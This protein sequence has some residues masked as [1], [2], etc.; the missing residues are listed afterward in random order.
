M[1][2]C[3][4]LA[5]TTGA[6]ASQKEPQLDIMRLLMETHAIISEAVL[7][8]ISNLS[9]NKPPELATVII[10]QKHRGQKH[11]LNCTLG[12]LSKKKKNPHCG[13]FYCTNK[14]PENEKR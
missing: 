2:G 5:S 7:P 8:K 10:L 4:H 1:T 14:L 11:M 6:K 12:M 13:K 3:K 9:L